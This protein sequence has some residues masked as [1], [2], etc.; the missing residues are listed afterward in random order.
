MTLLTSVPAERASEK[1]NTTH[2]SGPAEDWRINSV[3]V[4]VVTSM[5]TSKREKRATKMILEITPPA[6]APCIVHRP[7][8]CPY[9]IVVRAKLTSL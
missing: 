9:E 8:L 7:P 1:K 5:S 6:C 2:D 4:S 3:L